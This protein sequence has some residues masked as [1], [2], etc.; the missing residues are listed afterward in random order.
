MQNVDMIAGSMK[1]STGGLDGMKFHDAFL[2]NF[3]DTVTFRID[4]EIHAIGGRF[5]F[6]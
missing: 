6:S 4:G 5:V 1:V 3:M 2:V